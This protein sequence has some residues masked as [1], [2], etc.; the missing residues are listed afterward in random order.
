M[1][2]NYL[3]SIHFPFLPYLMIPLWLFSMLY[4][5]SEFKGLAFQNIFILFTVTFSTFGNVDTAD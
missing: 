2:L 5:I 1:Q 3:I 4:L